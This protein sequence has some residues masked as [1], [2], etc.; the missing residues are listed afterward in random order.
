MYV[1]CG[2]ESYTR[3]IFSHLPTTLACP[4]RTR[5]ERETSHACLLA[6]M[7]A[8]FRRV[9]VFCLPLL[10]NRFAKAKDDSAI[11]HQPSNGVMRQAQL[12]AD[13]AKG[14]L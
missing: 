12:R 7:H 14:L 4:W 1:C 10:K 13:H 2:Q 6:C 8:V 5:D 3:S 9:D 11:I